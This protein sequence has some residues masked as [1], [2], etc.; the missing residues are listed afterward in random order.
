MK[1]GI[2]TDIEATGI[3]QTSP[4][5]KTDEDPL[6]CPA[7]S[8]TQNNKQMVQVSSFTEYPFTLKRRLQVANFSTLTTEQTK[9]TKLVNP[10]AVPHLFNNNQ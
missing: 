10:I 3:I 8:T 1:A 4:L 5:L 9:H 2:H 7:F 6:N